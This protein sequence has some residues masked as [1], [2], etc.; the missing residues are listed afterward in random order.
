[1]IKFAD[2][3]HTTSGGKGYISIVRMVGQIVSIIDVLYVPSMISNLISVGQLL[4][5]GY[6]ME[7]EK[8]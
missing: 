8:N 1:M 6:N 4:A 5:K 2:D 3:R 7:L